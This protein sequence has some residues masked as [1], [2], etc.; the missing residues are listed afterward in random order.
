[1]LFI[2]EI[3]RFNKSQ[4]DA[5]L[6]SVENGDVILIGATTENPYFSVNSA[7]ISRS[8]VYLL[9]PLEV[10]ELEQVIT[11][12]LTHKDGYDGKIKLQPAQ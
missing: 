5:L 3:H 10:G 4:Q 7:L 6:P 9:K 8:Q 1:M 12:V 2:D 11:R